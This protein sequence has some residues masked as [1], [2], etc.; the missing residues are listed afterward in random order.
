VFDFLNRKRNWGWGR[1][2][3]TSVHVDGGGNRFALFFGV[4][5]R[6]DQFL[7]SRLRV[8]R[9]A[10][11]TAE[12]RVRVRYATLRGA[13]KRK[14]LPFD[15]PFRDFQKIISQA[16]VYGDGTASKALIAI[17]RKEPGKGYVRGNCV[18]SCPRHNLITGTT[19]L[20]EMCS[21]LPPC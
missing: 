15:L 2:E 14:G 9:Y 16:C 7:P 11:L 19:S 17:D 1:N 3:I 18:A 4:R 8:G 13:S 10:R 6:F 20:R 5:K 12:T 21:A